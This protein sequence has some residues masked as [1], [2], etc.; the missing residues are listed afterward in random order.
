M[1]REARQ[2]Q[3]DRQPGTDEAEGGEGGHLA[4]SRHRRQRLRHI[5]DDARDQAQRETRQQP[6]QA[7]PGAGDGA[8]AL[9]VQYV[10]DGDTDQ[11]GAEGERQQVQAAEETQGQCQ[12]EQ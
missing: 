9:Q 7:K 3:H 6:A 4:Q 8:I 11:A 5:G 1:E 2:P 10:I 12:R